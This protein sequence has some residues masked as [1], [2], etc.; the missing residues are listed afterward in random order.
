[1]RPRQK[2]RRLHYTFYVGVLAL[3]ANILVSVV[4]NSLTPASSRAVVAE[5]V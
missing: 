4:V 1:M 5:T 2:P 3:A